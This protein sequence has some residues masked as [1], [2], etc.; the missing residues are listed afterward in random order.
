MAKLK[1]EKNLRKLREVRWC[2]QNYGGKEYNEIEGSEMVLVK[3]MEERSTIKLRE[4][5]WCWQNS[6]RRGI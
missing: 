1:E 3:L 6:W 5:R 4:V 2:W